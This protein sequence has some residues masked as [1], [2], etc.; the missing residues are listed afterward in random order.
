MISQDT[1]QIGEKYR[2]IKYPEKFGNTGGPHTLIVG[3]VGICKWCTYRGVC[4]K[5]ENGDGYII[6]FDC[7]EV[8]RKKEEQMLLEM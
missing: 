3:A 2:I 8:F 1:I 7:L 5:L 4:I 6:P